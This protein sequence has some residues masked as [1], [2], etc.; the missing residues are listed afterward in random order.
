MLCHFHSGAILQSIRVKH[1]V[2]AIN[3]SDGCIRCANLALEGPFFEEESQIIHSAFDDQQKEL[4]VPD[5]SV[6]DNTGKMS[7]R[8][9]KHEKRML[10][11]ISS[12]YAQPAMIGK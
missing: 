7:L 2:E 10:E 8:L 12:E 9:L 6:R 3:A 4:H 5:P 11:V 1:Q